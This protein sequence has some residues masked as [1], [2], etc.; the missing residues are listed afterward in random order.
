MSDAKM[1][2]SKRIAETMRSP[3]QLERFWKKGKGDNEFQ[4]QV[5]NAAIRSKLIFGLES[6]ELKE[7]TTEKTRCISNGSFTTNPQKLQQLMVK[8]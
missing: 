2:M 6:V 3:R 8:W 7:T 1:E 5:Y 4:V